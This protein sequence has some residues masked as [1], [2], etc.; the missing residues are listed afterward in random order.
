MVPNEDADNKAGDHKRR[1]RFYTANDNEC[2]RKISLSVGM[3]G[4][5][6]RVW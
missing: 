3:S 4:L 2:I 5:L 1:I 6:I